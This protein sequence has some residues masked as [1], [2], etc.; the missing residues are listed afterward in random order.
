M[1]TEAK[2]NLVKIKIQNLYRRY[3]VAG[4]RLI[5]QVY[6]ISKEKLKNGLK[7]E[8]DT[9]FTGKL[10]VNFDIFIRILQ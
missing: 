1:W 5:K 2:E 4:M 10:I 3:L 6:L 7:I 8:N 9:F